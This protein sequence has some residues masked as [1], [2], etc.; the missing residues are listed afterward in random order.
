MDKILVREVISLAEHNSLSTKEIEKLKEKYD[1]KKLKL[2]IACVSNDLDTVKYCIENKYDLSI[3]NNE[4]LRYVV[5]SQFVSI[6]I[7]LLKNSV[8]EID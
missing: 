2:V 3:C 5:S 7:V 4:I 6:A 8:K 1:I